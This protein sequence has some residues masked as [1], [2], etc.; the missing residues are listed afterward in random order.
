MKE[1]I[2]ELI[3]TIAGGNAIDAEAQFNAIMASKMADRLD[4][5]RQEVASTLFTSPTEEQE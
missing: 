1:E 3:N 2:G 4:S 5:Y